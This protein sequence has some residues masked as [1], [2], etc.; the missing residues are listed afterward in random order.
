VKV[1]DNSVLIAVGRIVQEK[2]PELFARAAQTLKAPAVFVG[3]GPNLGSLAAICPS[4]V[5]T[6]WKSHSQV[7]ELMRKARALVFPSACY[8]TQGLVVLEAAALGLPA[9]VADTCAA[10]EFVEDG[11]TGLW[12]KG[13]DEGD[14]TCKLRRIIENADLVERLGRAAYDRFWSN[15]PPTMERHV[16]GLLRIYKEVLTSGS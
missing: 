6:G 14:L 16:E 9:V 11:V 10:R 8:E 3:D 15:L 4:A 7:V 2:G 12:F 5:F 13:A 1:R